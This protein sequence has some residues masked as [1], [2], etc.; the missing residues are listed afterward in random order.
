MNPSDFTTYPWSSVLQNSESETIAQNI[1]VILKRTGN[2]WRELPW[3][4]YKEERLKDN[5]F[6]ERERVYFEKVQPYTVSE[7]MARIFYAKWKE[8][9]KTVE[10]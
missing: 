10:V 7:D 3:E 8:V 4:E 5:N 6:S 9:K 1:M 2:I